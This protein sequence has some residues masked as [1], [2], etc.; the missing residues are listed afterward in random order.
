MVSVAARRPPVQLHLR[1]SIAPVVVLSKNRH[2]P[3]QAY[4]V[5]VTVNEGTGVAVDRLPLKEILSTANEGS[6]A[7]TSASFTQRKP[8]FTFELLSALAGREYV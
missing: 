7:V 1:L 2:W 6:V 8:I 5:G 3:V 4:N